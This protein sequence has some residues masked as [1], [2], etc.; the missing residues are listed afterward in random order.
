MTP[1]TYK[2]HGVL[3]TSDNLPYLKN[4]GLRAIHSEKADVGN[5]HNGRDLA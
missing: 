1:C 3:T 2:N 4:V 5:A